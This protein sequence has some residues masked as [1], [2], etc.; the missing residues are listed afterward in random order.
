MLVAD[1]FNR[2]GRGDEFWHIATILTHSG[3]IDFPRLHPVGRNRNYVSI[4]S[5][6]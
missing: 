2:L 3:R 4:R 1:G 5:T 6:H